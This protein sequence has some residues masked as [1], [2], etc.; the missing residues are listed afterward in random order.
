MGVDL[1][2]TEPGRERAESR[3]CS[4]TGILLAGLPLRVLPIIQRIVNNIY[5]IIDLTK[6]ISIHPFLV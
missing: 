1:P 5:E 2:E 3:R 4:G 6:F